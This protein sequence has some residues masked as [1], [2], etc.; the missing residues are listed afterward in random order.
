MASVSQRKVHIGRG[1]VTV[2]THSRKLRDH[3]FKCMPEA[4]KKNWDGS[5]TINSS[6]R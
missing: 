2:E 4:E 5:K 3:I 1:D 6:P